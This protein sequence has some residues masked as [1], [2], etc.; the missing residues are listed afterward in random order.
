MAVNSSLIGSS[1]LGL[2]FYSTAKSGSVGGYKSIKGD[3]QML[4]DL[5]NT[6]KSALDSSKGYEMSFILGES[7]AFVTTSSTFGTK[8]LKLGFSTSGVIGMTDLTKKQIE[9]LFN[10]SDSE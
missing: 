9:T 3:S 10:K 7:K 5:Y 2:T 8:Y 4:T 1:P 6:L